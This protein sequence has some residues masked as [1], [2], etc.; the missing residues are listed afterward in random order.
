VGY[1]Y[2][3]RYA[4]IVQKRKKLGDKQIYLVDTTGW[5]G[6]D[7]VYH[8][9]THPNE[10]GHRRV[11]AQFGAWLKKWGLQPKKSWPTST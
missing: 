7:D 1:Y 8:D 5:V 6:W 3:G 10:Q 2:D 4:E 9:N 11:A